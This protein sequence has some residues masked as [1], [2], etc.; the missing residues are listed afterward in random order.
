MHT[1][2]QAALKQVEKKSFYSLY[3]FVSYGSPKTRTLAG[4]KG[5]RSSRCRLI[6][7]TSY[8]QARFAGNHRI[9]HDVSFHTIKSLPRFLLAATDHSE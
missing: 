4:Q 3:I 5:V 6:Y 2:G 7:G 9:K 8:T 1:Q